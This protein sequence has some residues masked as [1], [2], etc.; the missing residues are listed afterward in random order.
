[1][2]NIVIY[3]QPIL[4]YVITFLNYSTILKFQEIVN[5]EG[6]YYKI[7]I[8][9]VAKTELNTFLKEKCNNKKMSI[10]QDYLYLIGYQLTN[11]PS[12]IGIL[13]NLKE[14]F[15]YDNQ[16]TSLPVSIGN[17]INLKELSISVNNLTSLP[18][19]IGNLINLTNLWVNHNQ[20][21]NLPSS[22]GNLINLRYL[23]LN[24][25]KLSELPKDLPKLKY[26]T[27]ANNRIKSI[28]KNL[29][30]EYIDDKQLKFQI[31][32]FGSSKF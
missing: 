19:S 20:L 5:L 25:N 31:I 27:I 28:P 7:E 23:G 9:T 30:I 17:L 29:N 13:V 6:T 22:I 2:K 32:E 21:T 3:H 10:E 1:M 16:L 11:L 26:L 18:D 12:S 24:N 4:D 14:L 15:I 8:D